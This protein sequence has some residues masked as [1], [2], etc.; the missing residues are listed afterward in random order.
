MQDKNSPKLTSAH[1]A[2]AT[3]SYCTTA[4]FSMLIGQ[5]DGQGSILPHRNSSAR[6]LLTGSSQHSQQQSPGAER[7]AK[8]RTVTQPPAA[9]KVLPEGKPCHGT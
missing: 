4:F 7:K 1:G 9:T 5:G 2:S 3:H 6:L 8:K